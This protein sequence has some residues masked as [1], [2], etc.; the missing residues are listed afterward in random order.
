[1]ITAVVLFLVLNTLLGS[2]GGH[3]K[4][5]PSAWSH[6]YGPPQVAG[7]PSSVTFS[8]DGRVLAVGA[9]GGSQSGSQA[10]DTTYLLN[11]RSGERIRKLSPGGG[12]EAFSPDGAMLATAGGPHDSVTYLRG[13]KSGDTF[14]TLVDDHQGSTVRSVSFSPNSKMLA[15]DDKNGVVYL[16]KLH[17]S[18]GAMT[19]SG[20]GSVT[21]PGGPN[22]NAVAF[23][24]RGTILALGGNDGQTY[25][26]DTATDSTTRTLGTPDNS[27]VTSVAFS[28]S[29]ALLASSKMD[30]MTYV[31]NLDTRNRISMADPDG[32]VIESVAFSPNS[33]WLATGD[34]D[35]HT[36]LWNLGA[37]KSSI[38]PAKVLT[39]PTSAT[40][41]G[42]GN[43]VFSVA[44][45][46][47]S[48]TLATT[49]TNGYIYLWQVP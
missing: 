4:I 2:P 23:S 6:V 5:N 48:N 3:R 42:A 10:K 38:K 13:L 17:G 45:G 40:P 36:Y 34:G 12:A 7:S 32:S 19:V 41:P 43:V 25:L 29:G 11:A 24:P 47:D 37:K 27:A 9:S 1:V 39:N 21:P 28:S 44:F 8:P 33:K 18:P 30:G 14:T 35:G 49:D 26:F 46:P 16:W 15:A 20:P 31:W 22:V